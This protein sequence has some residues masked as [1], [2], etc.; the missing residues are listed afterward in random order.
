MS[1]VQEF[2]EKFYSDKI[3]AAE[4]STRMMELKEKG[5]ED[6]CHAMTRVAAE[7][8]FTISPEDIKETFS[9]VGEDE[10]LSDDQLEIVAGGGGMTDPFLN[11]LTRKI[12]NYYHNN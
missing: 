8:G 2:L 12:Q 7:N 6:F 11:D 5:D 9:S 4:V 3:F 1:T 10:E